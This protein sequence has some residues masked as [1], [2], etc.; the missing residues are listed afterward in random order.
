MERQYLTV[1][2]LNRYLKFKFDHDANLQN[3]LLKAEISNFKRHS[4]GH[5]YFTLKDENSQISAVMFAGNQQKLVFQPKDGSKVIV[6][7]YVSVYEVTGSYQV[8]V[9]KMSEAGIGDLYQAFEMLKTKL[10]SEGL[11]AEEHKQALPRFPKTI[12]VVTSPTGAAIRDIIHI[13]NRRY[14][15]TGI[16]IYPTLVQ[17]EDAK[18]AIVDQ[19]KKANSDK[20]AE[21]LIVGRGGGSI[22][23]LWAFNEEIVA[24]AIYDSLIPVVS[25]VGHETDYTISD[26]VADRRAPTPSGAAEIVCPDQKEILADLRKSRERLSLSL[27][28]VFANK[29]DALARLEKATIFQRPKRLLETYELRFSS[30]YDRLQQ[31]KPD[32]LLKAH[33][34]QLRSLVRTLDMQIGSLY[35]IKMHKTVS[36]IE[37]LE[38]VNPLAIMRKGFAIV[39]KDNVLVKSISAVRTDDLVN[40]VLTDGNLDCR[41][42]AIRKD[43]S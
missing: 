41:V 16:I 42:E 23:D 10:A 8:Y 1:T 29:K 17:G 40:L 14:P 21:V 31:Q 9:T 32:K 36:L 28:K 30:A 6:E 39:K 43:V 18:Q 38:L 4:R 34:E 26:F 19:I 12:G 35:N 15:L 7:G 33:E 37:K 25:A 22:E 24:R 2:A 11:F 13:I 27:N 20:L 3:V 5:L